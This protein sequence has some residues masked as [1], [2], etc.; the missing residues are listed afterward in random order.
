MKT[1]PSFS[2]LIEKNLINNPDWVSYVSGDSPMPDKHGK[3]L[4]LI[5][6]YLFYMGDIN[7][8]R[9]VSYKASI[10][11][12]RQ[13]STALLQTYVVS[14]LFDSALYRSLAQAKD[15]ALRLWKEM[16]DRMG[17]IPEMEILEQRM[18][19]LW[20]YEAYALGRLKRYDEILDSAERGFDG[21]NKGKSTYKAP[22]NNSRVYGLVDI[23]VS[24]AN[25]QVANSINMQKKAQESLINYKKENLRYG[26]LGYDIIFD[27][28]FSYPHIFERV[29]PGTDP[30]QD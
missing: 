22:H 18:A 3:V 16:I 29:L 6:Q 13:A 25:Y 15:D 14:S 11:L 17:Q 27:L 28:Q 1:V 4:K 8:A 2:E 20:V 30:N 5:A 9:E 19:H 23:L 10:Y 7:H 12:E 21:I 26:R 24:L